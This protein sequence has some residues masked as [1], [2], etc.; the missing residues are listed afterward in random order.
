MT[1]ELY[2]Y[3]QFFEL[4][5]EHVCRQMADQCI[6]VI[7]WKHIFGCLFD[8]DGTLDLEREL[9]IFERVQKKLKAQFPIFQMKI[10]VCGLKLF[11]LPHAQSQIDAFFESTK[12]S[13]MCSGFDLVCEED[14]NPALEA[15][16]ELIYKAREKAAS[17]GREF[18]VYLH[19]GESNSR[20]NQQL[21]DAILL[22]TKRIGHGFHLAYHPELQKIVKE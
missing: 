13:N 3:A 1:F 10:V 14:Y 4:I 22:G 21:Y 16:L 15:Y 11:G 5:L 7:E 20:S 2:N 17:L 6:T 19:C 9:A 18:P 8:E 12:Y